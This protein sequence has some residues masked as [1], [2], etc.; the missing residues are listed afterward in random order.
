MVRYKPSREKQSFFVIISLFQKYYFDF[1]G[2][3]VADIVAASTAPAER[4]GGG[5]DLAL[6]HFRE[7][8]TTFIFF[9]RESAIC[10]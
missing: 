8:K 9:S 4:S 1:Q 10:F 3:R 5:G 7:E 2:K 6:P